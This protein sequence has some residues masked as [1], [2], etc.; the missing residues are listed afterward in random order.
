M[1]QPWGQSRS[2]ATG[3]GLDRPRH[4]SPLRTA[5]QR[6]KG[7]GRHPSGRRQVGYLRGVSGVFGPLPAWR[8]DWSTPLEPLPVPGGTGRPGRSLAFSWGAGPGPGQGTGQLAVSTSSSS[9]HSGSRGTPLSG[10]GKCHAS[11]RRR[12]RDLARAPDSAKEAIPGPEGHGGAADGRDRGE[13]PRRPVTEKEAPLSP[14]RLGGDGSPRAASSLRVCSGRP[15]GR[16]PI[17]RRFS[18]GRGG[19]WPAPGGS[20]CSG[21][22]G[23]LQR[24]SGE[25]RDRGR[26]PGRAGCRRAV[27]RIAPAGLDVPAKGTGRPRTARGRPTCGGPSTA[28][29]GGQPSPMTRPRWRPHSSPMQKRHPMTWKH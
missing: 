29:R 8:P 6:Q 2:H 9:F 4:A 18:G 15:S 17:V 19:G 28:R 23:R 13:A 12:S 7:A 22:G 20:S 3:R 21:R 11:I 27:T 26:V 24:P 25:A 1:G 16:W 14:V 10:V 5:S